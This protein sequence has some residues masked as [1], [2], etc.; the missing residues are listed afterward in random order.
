[1]VLRIAPKARSSKLGTHR[2]ELVADLMPRK[3]VTRVKEINSKPM[4]KA[5][6]QPWPPRKAYDENAI[7]SQVLVGPGAGRQDGDGYF[8]SLGNA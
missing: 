1:M 7:N 8:L 6:S 5:L 4:S 2:F 3:R